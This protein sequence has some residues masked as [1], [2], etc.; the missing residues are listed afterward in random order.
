MKRVKDGT[1]TLALRGLKFFF[2]LHSVWN[3]SR[4]SAQVDRRGCAQH[5]GI[6]RSRLKARG[7]RVRELIKSFKFLARPVSARVGWYASGHCR[8]LNP[9]L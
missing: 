5:G 4:E 2:L 8:R 9:V 7:K 1:H 3:G 6:G